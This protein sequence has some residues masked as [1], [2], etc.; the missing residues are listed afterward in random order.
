M[1]FRSILV[2]V[3]G[4]ECA[5]KALEQAVDI[6]RSEGARLTLISVATR[7][8]TPVAAGPFIV[9]VPSEEELL[10]QAQAVV[11][12]AEELVPDGVAV[13]TVVR[14]GV[15]AAEILKRVEDGE[16]DLVVMGS[17][18][19]GAATSLLLGS[20]GH[21]VLDHSPVPVLIVRRRVSKPAA[22]RP[23]VASA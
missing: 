12:R 8:T 16:H 18:G 17:R 21:A 9:P 23:E 14:Q 20:V 3:D 19:R 6:A 15:A 5:T 4:S 22:A 11:D 10:E 1:M 7:A 2:A 13:S